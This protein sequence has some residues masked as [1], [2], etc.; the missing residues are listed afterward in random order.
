MHEE[1]SIRK[2]IRVIR[3][4]RYNSCKICLIERLLRITI[5]N[6][7]SETIIKIK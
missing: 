2:E 4:I 3:K 6:S 7:I 1:V 5:S